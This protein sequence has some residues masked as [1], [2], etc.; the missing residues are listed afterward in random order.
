M[1]DYRLEHAFSYHAQLLAPE[2]IGAVAEGV[3][4]NFYV[5]GGEATGPQLSGRLRAG[6]GDW[7][8]LRT[9]G[10]GVLDVRATLQTADG[11]LVYIE[12]RGITD[13]GEDA[14]AQFLQGVMPPKLV[15]RTSPRL[16]CA[17][18]AHAW[19]NRCAFVGVGEIDMQTL[20]VSY[21]V[22]AVR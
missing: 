9:D 16:S 19:V 8:T 13:L 18:P 4:A 17:H 20:V 10:V 15:L 7:F 21:D 1:F 11:A 14:H 5:T 22:Y 6:G 2:V 3:R 12:Y